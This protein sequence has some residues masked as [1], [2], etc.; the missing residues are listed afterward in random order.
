MGATS[1]FPLAFWWEFHEAA[2]AV[3]SSGA[4]LPAWYT[5]GQIGGWQGR[6]FFIALLATV[7]VAAAARLHLWFTSR[8][9]PSELESVR[10][11]SSRWI[12]VADWRSRRRWRSVEC[13][14]ATKAR[15]WPSFFPWS[16][17]A[18]SSRFA[19]RAG[20]DTRCVQRSGLVN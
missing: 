9:Y 18:P 2:T 13:S 20:H 6:M 11:R 15:P 8:F 12:R 4:V 1:G 17:L 19:D 7:V 14:S 3:V 10:R 16:P 5:R